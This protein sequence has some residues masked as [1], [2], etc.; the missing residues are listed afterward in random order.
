MKIFPPAA[1]TAAGDRP[2]LRLT[3]RTNSIA[4]RCNSW[5]TCVLHHTANTLA[6]HASFPPAFHAPFPYLRSVSAGL[7]KLFWPFNSDT[8]SSFAATSSGVGSTVEIGGVT[9]HWRVDG[10]A[11]ACVVSVCVCGSMYN[12]YYRR[13]DRLAPTTESFKKTEYRINSSR[14]KAN[15]RSPTARKQTPKH[16]RT[17]QKRHAVERSG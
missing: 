5:S 4:T 14:I 8:N 2:F 9:P 3:T 6:S 10:V 17:K 7:S 1:S 15:E 11:M 13:M 16:N 12:L